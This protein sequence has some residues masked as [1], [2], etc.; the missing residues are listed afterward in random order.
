MS[1]LRPDPSCSFKERNINEQNTHTQTHTQQILLE[2]FNKD[3]N[4]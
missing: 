4:D 3:E 1:K 2:T